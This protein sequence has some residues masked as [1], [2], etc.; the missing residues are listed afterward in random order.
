MSLLVCTCQGR[1]L[2]EDWVCCTTRPISRSEEERYKAN[3]KAVART[4]VLILELHNQALAGTIVGLALYTRI[5]TTYAV[6]LNRGE[7]KVARTP[8]AAELDLIT[9]EVCLVFHH[10]N[11]GLQDALR[12]QK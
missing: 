8:A 10:L 5:K 12:S 11:K 3:N 4:V 9:L 6:L 7:K 1:K 2:N